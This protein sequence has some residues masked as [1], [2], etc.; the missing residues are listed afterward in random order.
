MQTIRTRVCPDCK[1]IFVFRMDQKSVEKFGD[2]PFY[3]D[4]DFVEHRWKHL[5]ANA[6]VKVLPLKVSEL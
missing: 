4:A 1:E 2:N 6:I 5:L 3:F